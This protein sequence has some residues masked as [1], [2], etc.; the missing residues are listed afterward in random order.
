MRRTAED[1]ERGEH[2]PGQLTVDDALD[3]PEQL[4]LPGLDE[5][6]NDDDP[7]TRAGVRG[8]L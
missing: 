1:L 7:R 5:V 6:P 2:V 3:P 4:I 8:S